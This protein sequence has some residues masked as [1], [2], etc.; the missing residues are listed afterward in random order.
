[1]FCKNIEAEFSKKII[2]IFKKNCKAENLKRNFFCDKK[3]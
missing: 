3:L 1:M 2:I